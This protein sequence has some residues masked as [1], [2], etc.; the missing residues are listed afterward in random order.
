MEAS[1]Q[2]SQPV[3]HRMEMGVLESFMDIMLG[4]VTDFVAFKLYNIE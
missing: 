4:L 3:S 2:A 1:K